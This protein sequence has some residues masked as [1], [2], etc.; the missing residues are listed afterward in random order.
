MKIVPSIAL[1]LALISGPAFAQLKSANLDPQAWYS[2]IA[3]H[4]GKA[5]EI[6]GGIEGKA[7]GLPLQQNVPTGAAN[8]LFQFKQIKSGFFQIIVKHSGKVLE[9]RNNSPKALA[10]IQQDKPNGKDFQLFTLVQD[11][12]GNYRIISR[13]TGYG[14]DVSGGVTAISNNTP[15]IVYPATGASNQMFSLVQARDKPDAPSTP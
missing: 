4:S 3:A 10:Q 9:I 13:S 11:S 8:Q 14:F 5:L 6:A 1:L 15:V 7:D 2:I 12:S